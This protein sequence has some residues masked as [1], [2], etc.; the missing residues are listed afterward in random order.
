M[1]SETRILLIK[2]YRHAVKEWI[3]KLQALFLQRK[4]LKACAQRELA[5]ETGYVAGCLEKIGEIVPVPDFSDDLIHLFLGTELKPGIQGLEE[6]EILR[7]KELKISDV[8]DMIMKGEIKDAKTIIGILLT[9]SMMCD[10][11][12]EV[13]DMRQVAKCTC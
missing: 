10:R 8:V 1:L 4:I 12:K 7:V 13:T 5:E 6:D 2:Q 3:W 11:H 9:N